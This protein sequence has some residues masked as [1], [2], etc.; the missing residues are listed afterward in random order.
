[1]VSKFALVATSL[2]VSIALQGCGSSDGPS[3]PSTCKEVKDY[4]MGC[5]SIEVPNLNSECCDTLKKDII[6]VSF[7]GV[8]K[9]GNPADCQ[10]EVCSKCNGQGP[11]KVKDVL[12]QNCSNVQTNLPLH[13]YPSLG[14][15]ATVPKSLR[16]SGDASCVATASDC[17]IGVPEV[18][19]IT[20]TLVLKSI[21]SDCCSTMNSASEDLIKLAE[22]LLQNHSKPDPSMIPKKD[23][24][25]VCSKCSSEASPLMTLAIQLLQKYLPDDCKANATG[26]AIVDLTV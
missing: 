20:P 7:P 6:P 25:A 14:V 21:G 3:G 22:Q 4:G 11:Q 24:Q 16:S 9:C 1:M 10:K 12:A 19:G 15:A 5:M 23:V 26:E 13:V 8:P 18:F 2:L 17:K